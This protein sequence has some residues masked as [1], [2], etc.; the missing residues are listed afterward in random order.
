MAVT[1]CPVPALAQR[2]A[3]IDRA[4]LEHETLM[5][6]TSSLAEVTVPLP[7]TGVAPPPVMV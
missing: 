5:P 4:V 7:V 3:V 1:G 6:V 2:H